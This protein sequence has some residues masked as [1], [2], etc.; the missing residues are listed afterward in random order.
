M[1]KLT[2]PFIEQIP[3]TGKLQVIY[4]DDKKAPSG[5]GVTVSP[6][7]VKSYFVRYAYNGIDKRAVIGK[8]ADWSL[9]AARLEAED[10]RKAFA[11]GRDLKAERRAAI[12]AAKQARRDTREGRNTLEA[13]IGDYHAYL[14]ARGKPS[15]GEAYRRLKRHVIDAQPDLAKKPAR[16][17]VPDD[18]MTIIRKVAGE[19]K[20][21]TADQV[22]AY[23]RAA[24]SIAMR[25]PYDPLLPAEL[26][27]YGVQSDPT[28][29]I[30]VIPVRTSERV[31]TRKELVNYLHAIE[32]EDLQQKALKLALYAGGQRMSQLL[33]AKLS[34]Y[35]AEHKTLTLYDGKG[36]RAQPRV[37]VLPLGPVAASIVRGLVERARSLSSDESEDQGPPFL[38]ASR[39]AAM[40]P[41]EPGKYLRELI[42][43]NGW[44]SFNLRDVRRT[45]E[46][47]MARL[48]IGKDIR[49]HVLSH[50]IG[51]LQDK[52][53]DRHAYTTEKR[54][55]LRKWER[56]LAGLM[57]PKKKAGKVVALGARA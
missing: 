10:M 32:G 24:Y 28:A 29:P 57:A 9:T 19:G 12:E 33:R 54:E 7:G 4:D 8:V 56:H 38:F 6:K 36:K 21:R 25:A 35:D 26:K 11:Q 44:P 5:F 52:H 1:A 40:Y 43:A 14:K 53:Y 48:G 49:A 3:A 55:A 50:G 16:E 2:K 13:L 45:V 18:V 51:G 42:D 30:A 17:I 23:L 34:D 37:H 22:R 27:D 20:E 39:G 31:L 46:T 15:A 41:G 47:E